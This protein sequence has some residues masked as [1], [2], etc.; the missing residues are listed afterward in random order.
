MSIAVTEAR[1]SVRRAIARY[2]KQQSAYQLDGQ[3][4]TLESMSAWADRYPDKLHRLGVLW[5][6]QDTLRE[7]AS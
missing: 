4:G 2:L 5:A 3:R 1:K 7:Y 6:V